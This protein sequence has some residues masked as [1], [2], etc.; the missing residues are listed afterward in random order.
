MFF[1]FLERE[2]FVVS[3]RKSTDCCPWV[4]P[5]PILRDGIDTMCNMKMGVL[6]A[7]VISFCERRWSK[8]ARECYLDCYQ[9][10]YIQATSSPNIFVIWCHLEFL[11]STTKGRY[12]HMLF[13]HSSPP[14]TRT[15]CWLLKFSYLFPHNHQSSSSS[16]LSITPSRSGR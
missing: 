8:I 9:D 2:R 1:S 13:H 5:P 11:P 12:F 10:M 6:I 15:F 7:D 14:P 16:S 3:A 4:P